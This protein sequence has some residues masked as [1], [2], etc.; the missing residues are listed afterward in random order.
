VVEEANKILADAGLSMEHV[1]AQTFSVKLDDIERLEHLIALTET[2][3]NGTLRELERHQQ[4]LAQKV[5]RIAQDD[6]RRLIESTPTLSA[7]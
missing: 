3:R 2:R 6:Q 5:R 1:R 4:M 7:E